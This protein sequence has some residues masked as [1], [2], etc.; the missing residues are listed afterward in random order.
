MSGSPTPSF[1]K[2]GK[3]DYRHVEAL[4]SPD[5]H[6]NVGN[7]YANNVNAKYA[8]ALNHSYQRR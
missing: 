2:N 5:S 7:D 3:E 4:T 8:V 6:I 1:A